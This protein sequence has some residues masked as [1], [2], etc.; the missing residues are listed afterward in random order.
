MSK[1][2]L[3]RQS[4]SIFANNNILIKYLIRGYQVCL[5]WS[6]FP[7]LYATSAVI[8]ASLSL[9]AFSLEVVCIVFAVTFSIY[10]LNNIYDEDEDQVN[11]PRKAVFVRDH[12]RAI[13]GLVVV[14]YLTG[15]GVSFRGGPYA[16]VVTL[17]P[18]LAGIIYSIDLIRAKDIMVLNTTIVSAALAVTVVG[19]PLAFHHRFPVVP[20][21]LLFV[22]FLLKF[23][24]TVEL[25][26]IPDIEGD[27]IAG[28]STLPVVFGVR[29]TKLILYG[30]ETVAFA[31]VLVSIEYTSVPMGVL[32]VFAPATLY[33]FGSIYITE[34]D[35]PISKP[36][37]YGDFQL[38]LMG[39]FA[40]AVL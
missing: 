31:L 40:L 20:S 13:C 37:V 16:P 14:A 23:S 33:S 34:Q 26:N 25:C 15:L 18:L 11:T 29:R 38:F 12:R 35:P 1:E 24:I 6:L 32:F 5:W 30:L 27:R 36:S 7:S 22:C 10:N 21:L 39:L 19:L 3:D 9:S 8:A 2:D 4:K 17:I 28:V